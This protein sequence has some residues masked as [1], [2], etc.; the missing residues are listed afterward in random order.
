MYIKHYLMNK[1][2]AQLQMYSP[3]FDPDGFRLER[4]ATTLR[5]GPHRRETW[6][7]QLRMRGLTHFVGRSIF[8]ILIGRD[9]SRVA[10]QAKGS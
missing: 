4:Y 6:R 3:Y 5:L 2:A 8:S 10:I 9:R 1:M 7:L